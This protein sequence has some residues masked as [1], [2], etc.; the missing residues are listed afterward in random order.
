MGCLIMH[1]LAFLAGLQNSKLPTANNAFYL[2]EMGVD[3]WKLRNTKPQ[4]ILV[5]V[6][7]DDSHEFASSS[8]LLLENIL[9]STNIPRSKFDVFYNQKEFIKDVGSLRKYIAFVTIGEMSAI[10]LP[11]KTTLF[12]LPQL[13]LLLNN[14][15]SKKQSYKTL[16]K[17][18]ECIG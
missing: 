13:S 5:L 14:S 8:K 11:E 9:R 3:V 10:K 1:D 7:S 12:K 17:I 6:N 18:S 4:Q 15:Q 2:Q 16:S